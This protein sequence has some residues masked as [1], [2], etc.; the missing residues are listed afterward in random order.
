MSERCQARRL[1]RADGVSRFVSVTVDYGGFRGRTARATFT[2]RSGDGSQRRSWRQW[3]SR[4]GCDRAIVDARGWDDERGLYDG[5][6]RVWP[7]STSWRVSGDFAALE[8]LAALP[9]VLS[10]TW[11]DGGPRPARRRNGRRD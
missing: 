2:V 7:Q 6:D 1:I 5:R 11:D 8:A 10:V 4:L 3:V 9:V